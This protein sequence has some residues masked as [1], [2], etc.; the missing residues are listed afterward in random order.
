M[1]D[2]I[3]LRGLTVRGNHGVFDYE[4]ADGQN[5]V[6]DI[7]VWIDLAD[8]ATSDDLADTFDYG[9]LAQRAATV[10]AGPARNL[11]ETV[12][13]EIAE[14]VMNDPR[15]HAVEVT[16]HKPQAPIAQTFGDVAVVARRSRRGGRGQ[17][18]PA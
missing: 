1:A 7:T 16:V 8:A 3:E 5:F 9:V 10:V 12:A 11:I 15:V 13:G 18:V 4:R 14:D 17:V 6:V 2:R